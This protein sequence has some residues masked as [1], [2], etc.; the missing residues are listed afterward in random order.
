MQWRCQDTLGTFNSLPFLAPSTSSLTHAC[1]SLV[2]NTT[3]PRPLDPLQPLACTGLINPIRVSR[4]RRRAEPSFQ[5]N[6]YHPRPPRGGCSPQLQ[7]SFVLTQPLSCK[8]ASSWPTARSESAVMGATTLK[9]MIP[10]T[11]RRRIA[12]KTS[13][14]AVIPRTTA[15]GTPL[16]VV[17]AV[18]AITAAATTT[19]LKA[20]ACRTNRPRPHLL[21]RLPSKQ[22]DLRQRQR[23]RR[24]RHQ[25][26]YSSGKSKLQLPSRIWVW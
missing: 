12:R 22:I 19:P 26:Q 24:R 15:R 23:Q 6:L 3:H 25:P 8:S 9:T 5:H 10:Q 2:F 1:P 18:V 21:L 17:G 13:P 16:A 11:A 20:Q 4:L 14:T 7:L